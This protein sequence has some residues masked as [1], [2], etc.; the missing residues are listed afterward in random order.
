MSYRGRKGQ[1]VAWWIGR[2]MLGGSL[3]ITTG[4]LGVESVAIAQ[5]VKVGYVNLGLVFDGYE[6]TKQADAVLEKKGGKKERELEGRLKEL[7]KLHDGLELLGSD[8]REH[9]R[10]EVQAKGNRFMGRRAVRDQSRYDYPSSREPRFGIKPHVAA[11]S[12]WARI[13]RLQRNR[14]WLEA[15]EDALGLYRAG[16]RNVVFPHGTYKMRIVHAVRC[17]PPP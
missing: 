5:E 14:A 8:A 6:R 9:K 1:Q 13:E 11:K 17:R 10:R 7:K 16:V 2:A 12:K 3:V 4:A 15:Y